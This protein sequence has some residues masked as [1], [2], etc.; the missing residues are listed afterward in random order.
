MEGW[1]V[2]LC[3]CLW[4][5]GATGCLEV[6]QLGGETV[7][8]LNRN[9]TW[10]WKRMGVMVQGRGVGWGLGGSGWLRGWVRTVDENK[11]CFWNMHGQWN[12]T[13]GE[14]ERGDLPGGVRV[15]RAVG[16]DTE[17]WLKGL[18]EECVTPREIFLHENDFNGVGEHRG[19]S[20]GRR[21]ERQRR[22]PSLPVASVTQITQQE[23]G[24]KRKEHIVEE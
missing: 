11:I 22:R 18:G 1:G 2:S 20:S 21:P 17:W 6:V 7:V 12:K 9:R 3:V 4:G 5:G 8:G 19:L 10:I 14:G 16:G 13:K 23:G 15:E 24:D